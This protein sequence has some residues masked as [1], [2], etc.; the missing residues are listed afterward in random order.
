MIKYKR[1]AWTTSIGKLKNKKIWRIAA[2]I[3]VVYFL[4]TFFFWLPFV[5]FHITA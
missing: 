5:S 4:P 2:Q 3:T 1:I